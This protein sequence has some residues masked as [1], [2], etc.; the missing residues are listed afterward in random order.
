MEMMVKGFTQDIHRAQE[1]GKV[2]VENL[3]FPTSLVPALRAEWPSRV[4]Q[5]CCVTAWDLHPE[6]EILQWRE[7]ATPFNLSEL[8][9]LP[10]APAS[11]GLALYHKPRKDSSL[12]NT[13]TK[14]P[15]FESDIQ[16]SSWD[17]NRTS[18][19]TERDKLPKKVLDLSPD[20]CLQQVGCIWVSGRDYC[21]GHLRKIN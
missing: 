5:S 1:A 6:H 14:H 21:I 12:L 15:A 16:G 13:S 20:R 19:T 11:I 9:Y 7:Q 2:A 8:S 3:S 4:F 10:S 18:T 17:V